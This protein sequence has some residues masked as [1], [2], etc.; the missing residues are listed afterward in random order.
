MDK[1]FG[2]VQLMNETAKPKKY[3]CL[4]IIPTAVILFIAFGIV[5]IDSPIE[6]LQLML[7]R[8]L[9]DES[10]NLVVDEQI[11]IT[12]DKYLDQLDFN[13]LFSGKLA[14][15]EKSIFN[16]TKSPFYRPIPR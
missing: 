7:K 8:E 3:I 10:E 11:Q 6:T 13:Y 1:K 2:K 15:L 9:W 14:H 5:G 16:K 12:T 4:L